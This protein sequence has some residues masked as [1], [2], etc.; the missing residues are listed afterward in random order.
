MNEDKL[1]KLH[2]DML[3]KAYIQSTS[4]IY[5]SLNL[6]SRGVKGNLRVQTVNARKHPKFSR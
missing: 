6:L 4:L 2:M 3:N 5:T 1:C